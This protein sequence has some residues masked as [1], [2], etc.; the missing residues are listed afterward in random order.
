M[1]LPSQNISPDG[2]TH[3]PF[4]HTRPPSHALAQLEPAC[5]VHTPLTQLSPDAH[6][7]PHAPQF[8]ASACTS[9]HLLPQAVSTLLPHVHRPATQFMSAPQALSHAPQLS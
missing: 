7:W 1:Q 9:T 5:F 4:A 2:H 6:A 3:A 8:E